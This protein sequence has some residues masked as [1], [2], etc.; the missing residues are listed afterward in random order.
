MTNFRKYTLTTGREVFAG[1]D[2]ENNDLLVKS[3]ARNETLLHTEAPGSPFVKCGEKPLKK[4]VK[5]TAVF[6][7]K[8]SQDWRDHKKDIVVNVFLKADMKKGIFM[9]KGTWNV[10][11][12][13]KVTVKK[14]DILR[15]EKEKQ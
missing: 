5:E 15:F 9:K 13:E 14:V 4:E 2:A 7:A 3:A 8:Y 10:K 12:Q 11:K 1:R 6:C